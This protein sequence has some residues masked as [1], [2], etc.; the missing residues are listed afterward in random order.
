MKTKVKDLDENKLRTSTEILK[1]IAHPIRIK[2]MCLLDKGK[3]LSVSE[4]FSNLDIE[5]AVVSHHLRILKDRDVLDYTRDGK[6]TYY[7][8]KKDKLNQVIDCVI[9]C[10]EA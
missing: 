5:Q 9:E 1:A 3:K 6:N 2:I 8:M 7:F 4:L 10:C